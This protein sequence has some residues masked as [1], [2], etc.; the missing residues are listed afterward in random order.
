MKKILLLAIVPIA[1]LFT[2]CQTQPVPTG[3]NG[4]SKS[5]LQVGTDA[6]VF[7]LIDKISFGGTVI[8][9]EDG[10]TIKVTK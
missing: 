7:T 2:G 4:K 1:L 5:T 6:H 10:S 8:R 9:A 3:V